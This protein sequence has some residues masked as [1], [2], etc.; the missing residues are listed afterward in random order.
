[1]TAK[2]GGFEG[3]ALKQGDKLLLKDQRSKIKDQSPKYKISQQL[4]PS[5]SRFPTV[6]VIAGAEFDLLTALS[7]ETFLKENFLIAPNSDRMGFRLTG[8]SI[9]LLEEKELISSAVNFGTI[10]L[11]PDGQM[12]I[13]MADHQT[14]G[15]Y[16]RLANVIDTDLPLVAQLGAGDKLAFHLITLEE[17]ENISLEFER[18]LNLLKTAVKFL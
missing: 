2:V 5:Y 1:L 13:L 14:S 6:R 16:P 9:Y 11:L 15:G 12:I 18:D 3:R 8:E 10:Q 4:F 17:A 7:Q